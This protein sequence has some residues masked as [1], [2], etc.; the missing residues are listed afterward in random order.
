[1]DQP[2]YVEAVCILGLARSWRFVTDGRGEPTA[3]SMT[4]GAGDACPL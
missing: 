2:N 3:R 1:M 4:A